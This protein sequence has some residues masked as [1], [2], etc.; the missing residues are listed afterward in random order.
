MRHG[1]I[2]LRCHDEKIPDLTVGNIGLRSVEQP[3][4]AFIFGSRFHPGEIA[5]GTGLR[6]GNAENRFAL[7]A[8]R[9]NAHFLFFGAEMPDVRAH[10]A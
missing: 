6:H 4:I 7:D 3:M 2:G 1:G 10:Q 8:L 9:Q 5:A